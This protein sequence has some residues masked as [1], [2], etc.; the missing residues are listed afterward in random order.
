[1][2][3]IVFNSDVLYLNSNAVKITPEFIICENRIE[4]DNGSFANFARKCL[5][6]SN[7]LA[8]LTRSMISI[9]V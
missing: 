8:M 5:I 9:T 2:S 4:R 3:L 7:S 1:M 6:I